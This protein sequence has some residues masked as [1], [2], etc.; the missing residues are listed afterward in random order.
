MSK[1]IK[2]NKYFIIEDLQDDLDAIF[3]RLRSVCPL[4][5]LSESQKDK[6]IC[7]L[8]HISA[9]ASNFKFTVS[10]FLSEYGEDSKTF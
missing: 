3:Q 10:N 7:K 6:F 2:D 9:L 5:T 1:L 8:Y 4:T